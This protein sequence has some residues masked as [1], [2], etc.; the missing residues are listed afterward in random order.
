M[1]GYNGII[2][3]NQTDSYAYAKYLCENLILHQQNVMYCLRL[4]INCTYV[5]T[6]N[7]KLDT[8]TYEELKAV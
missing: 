2:I 8:H 5:Y 7:I 4:C 3:N 6:Y 1:N